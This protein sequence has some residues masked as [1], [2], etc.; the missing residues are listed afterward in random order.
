MAPQMRFALLLT[1]LAFPFLVAVFTQALEPTNMK[2]NFSKRQV[3]RLLKRKMSLI[4]DMIY[5]FTHKNLI[6]VSV[7]LMSLV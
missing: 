2:L 4:A 3:L 6:H 7:R 5:V 1:S